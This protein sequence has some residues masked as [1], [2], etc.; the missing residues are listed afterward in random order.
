MCVNAYSVTQLQ[1]ALYE[2][3]SLY[4][5]EKESPN[6]FTRICNAVQYAFRGS[7]K[8]PELQKAKNIQKLVQATKSLDTESEKFRALL[9]VIYAIYRSQS[10]RFRNE[11]MR[12]TVDTLG[13]IEETLSPDAGFVLFSFRISGLGHRRKYGDIIAFLVMK[14]LRGDI[15]TQAVNTLLTSPSNRGPFCFVCI[16][17]LRKDSLPALLP[18]DVLKIVFNESRV[19][20]LDELTTACKNSG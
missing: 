2:M 20:V 4:I 7:T 3:A 11:I 9:V 17:R 18:K 15:N 14:C 19:S 16:S 1:D 5:K 6:L 10:H 13:A 8:D 12:K